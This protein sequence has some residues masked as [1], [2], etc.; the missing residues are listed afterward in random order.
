MSSELERKLTLRDLPLL[1]GGPIL[2]RAT[3]SE[4]MV[5]FAT[6]IDADMK[7]DVFEPGTRRKWRQA[8]ESER[9][10]GK[11]SPLATGENGGRIKADFKIRCGRH[12]YVHLVIVR[13]IPGKSLGGGR[14]LEYACSMAA[15]WP[16]LDLEHHQKDELTGFKKSARKKGDFIPLDILESGALGIGLKETDLPTFIVQGGAQPSLRFVYGSCRKPHGPGGDA[17]VAALRYLEQNPGPSSRPHFLMLGGD[18]IYVD[19]ASLLFFRLLRRCSR[20]FGPDPG[21]HSNRGEEKLPGAPKLD[22]EEAGARADTVKK[23]AALTSGHADNHMMQFAE[24]VAAYL[25]AWNGDLR[26]WMSTADLQRYALDARECGKHR[27]KYVAEAA[28][29]GTY[30]AGSLAA[31]VVMA[32]TPLY[33]MFDDHDVTDDWNITPTWQDNVERKKLGVRI[34]A[35]AQAAFWLF[36]AIGNGPWT[37]YSS[38][39]KRIRNFH[40]LIQQSRAEGK[41]FAIPDARIL[42]WHHWSYETPTTPPVLVVDTRTHRASNDCDHDFVGTTRAKRNG[43]FNLAHGFNQV[44]QGPANLVGYNL[45]T[46]QTFARAQKSRNVPLVMACATPV[47]GYEPVEDLQ[48]SINGLLSLNNVSALSILPTSFLFAIVRALVAKGL[49]KLGIRFPKD[50][51]DS[52]WAISPD[53]ADFEGFRANPRS[54]MEVVNNVILDSDRSEFTMIL[55]GD[56]HYAFYAA[57]VMQR[58]GGEF[59]D[60]VQITSSGM[61]NSPT[62]VPT[63]LES[64]SDA[65]ERISWLLPGTRESK[66]WYWWSA[67]SGKPLNIKEDEGPSITRPDENWDFMVSSSLIP[68]TA[69]GKALAR[70]DKGTAPELKSFKEQVADDSPVVTASNVAFVEIHKVE[71]DWRWR[72]QLLIA[73]ENNTVVPLEFVHGS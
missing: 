64:G 31:R 65:D 58:F 45:G 40:Q 5:W 28:S 38:M 4:L 37:L 15:D 6:S 41:D 43:T 53:V 70:D 59:R 10:I 49:N 19:D 12:L 54:F 69:M 29:L 9:R 71:Q 42:N 51:L 48:G 2:R 1:L 35:N 16:S 50:W 8:S 17:M 44:E 47:F 67:P 39:E 60:F 36:Q 7:V 13:P 56:V 68:L 63:R 61:K 14:T 22:L 20:V 57:G 46:L 21:K 3:A 27:D 66:T 73:M 62:V 25:L 72:S 55:S 24:I 32:N 26:L 34:L 33:T 11:F 18:Q 30:H 52:S 23:H